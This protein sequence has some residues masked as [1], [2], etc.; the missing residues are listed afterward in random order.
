[1]E[2]ASVTTVIV[3]YNSV[4]FMHFNQNNY[5]KIIFTIRCFSWRIVDRTL[6]KRGWV[7]DQPNLKTLSNLTYTVSTFELY[8]SII[9]NNIRKKVFQKVS[10]IYYFCKHCKFISGYIMCYISRHG[11]ENESRNYF[12]LCGAQRLQINRTGLLN[13]Y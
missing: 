11:P 2:L 6:F 8:I 5:F 9:Y 10:F 13:I 1:M 3:P 7:C 4:H 12:R